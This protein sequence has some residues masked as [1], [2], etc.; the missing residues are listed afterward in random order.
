MTD[1][2]REAIARLKRD[3]NTPDIDGKV[4]AVFVADLALLI[5]AVEAA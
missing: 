1:E 3:L 4:T 5:A 2:L